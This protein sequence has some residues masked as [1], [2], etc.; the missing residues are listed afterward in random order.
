[1]CCYVPDELQACQAASGMQ[2]MMLV[3]ERHGGKGAACLPF[4]NF[5]VVHNGG[6]IEVTVLHR[7]YL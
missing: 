4:L 6:R 3:S 5:S 2:V 7:V 1:M